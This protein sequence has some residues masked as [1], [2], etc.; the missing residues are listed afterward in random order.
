M[1]PGHFQQLPGGLPGGLQGVIPSQPQPAPLQDPAI[2][3][4][5]K[6]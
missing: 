4:F 2:M 6:V 5:S 1:P 3:S